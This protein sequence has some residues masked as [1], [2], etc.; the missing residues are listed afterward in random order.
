VILWVN[1]NRAVHQRVQ[2]LMQN[3]E[4]TGDRH[5]ATERAVNDPRAEPGGQA[6]EYVASC[7]I[8]QEIPVANAGEHGQQSEREHRDLDDVFGHE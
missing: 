5:Q 8:E 7:V 6:G 2:T 1:S 4:Q 3:A